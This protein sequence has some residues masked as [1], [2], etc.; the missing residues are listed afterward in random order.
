MYHI[1]ISPVAKQ[2]ALTSA[3]DLG[4]AHISLTSLVT[5]KTIYATFCTCHNTTQNTA[6][7]VV[8]VVDV[9]QTVQNTR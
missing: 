8:V 2:L 1:S 5:L 7:I 3:T 9:K 6:G 4:R